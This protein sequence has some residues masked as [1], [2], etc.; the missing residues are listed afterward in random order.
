[1]M[2]DK[3]K[4]SVFA[5]MPY[6]RRIVV[7]FDDLSTELFVVRDIQF[8]F[9]VKKSIKFFSLEKIVNQSA[10]AFLAEYFVSQLHPI[11]H[12]SLSFLAGAYC[13]SATH[14][15]VTWTPC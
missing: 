2:Q 7:D 13:H 6:R 1:M 5:R 4:H 9:V 15:V 12:F 11:F 10:R 8:L 3:L 14:I